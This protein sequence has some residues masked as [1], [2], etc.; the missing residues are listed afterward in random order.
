MILYKTIAAEA[1]AATEI[2]RS[3]FLAHIS[4]AATREE[5]EAYLDDL[6]R[7]YRDAT[8]NVPAM[9]IGE[10]SELQWASDD[11]EPQ[12]TAGAPMLQVLLG[13]GLTNVVLV[14][15][16]WFGGIKLGTGGLVR[17]YTG[18]ARAVLE[19]AEVRAVREICEL[20]V[21][22]DYGAA[23]R[24][25][26]LASQG[27]FAIAGSRYEEAVT[28]VL[29]CEKEDAPRLRQLLADLAAGEEKIVSEVFKKS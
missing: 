11:G 16:R 3:R 13:A 14:V 26:H 8:H 17:A 23:A 18:A 27:L 1:E 6:R 7:R 4:P 25:P 29:H 19:E 22:L 2:E 5:A 9:V 28:A 10:H 20:T 15:T 21:R 12:G 24:L